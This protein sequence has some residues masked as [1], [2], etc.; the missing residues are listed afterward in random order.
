[1]ARGHHGRTFGSLRG[2]LLAGLALTE[3]RLSLNGVATAVLEGGEAA[4]AIPLDVLLL[5][6]VPATLIWGRH[7]SATPLSVQAESQQALSLESSH[8]RQRRGRPGAGA[9]GS[10]HGGA[11]RGARHLRLRR[12]SRGA[13]GVPPVGGGSDKFLN[14]ARRTRDEYVL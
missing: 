5:I 9:A 2:Q 7:D 12:R 10:M 1:M 4:P 11:A 6:A 14:H 13:G 3:R 8:H